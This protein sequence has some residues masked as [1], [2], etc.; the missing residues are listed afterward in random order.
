M[1]T[2]RS[3]EM[4]ELI[5]LMSLS[6]TISLFVCHT[7]YIYPCRTLWSFLS[8]VDSRC[9]Y[10]P[11]IVGTKL[12]ITDFNCSDYNDNIIILQINKNFL[13]LVTFNKL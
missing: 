9:Y 1:L 13:I 5:L 12:S 11:R 4:V 2:S 6:F 3:G 7:T 8:T 10:P